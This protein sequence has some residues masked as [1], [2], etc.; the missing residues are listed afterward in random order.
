M[1]QLPR[2]QHEFDVCV[3]GGG[4]AGMIAAMASARHGAKTCLVHDRPVLG[5]NASSEVRMW[6]CGPQKKNLKETGILEEIQLENYY[7]NP[8]LNYSIWDSVLYGKAFFEPNL[9]TFLNTTCNGAEMD[10]DRIASVT[11]WT[12]T[13]QTWQVISAKQFIDCSGDGILGGVTPALWRSGR[14]SREE[15]N[16]SIQPSQADDKTMGNSLLIQIRKTDSPQPFIP[17]TWAYK[18]TSPS[19]IPYR[20]S[21]V[22][23]SNFW[24]IELGGLQDTIGD[25]EAIRDELMRAVYGIWDYIKNHAAE[26]EEAANWALEWIG[27]LP[28]KRENRRFVGDHILTQNDIREQRHFDDIVAYG[29]WPMDDHHPAGLLYPGQPTIFHGAPA[30]YAIPLRCLYSK[31]IPNMLFAGRNISATHIAFAS[32]RVMATC[33]VGGQAVGTA[34]ALWLGEKS[35][36][37]RALSTPANVRAL[38]QRLLRD[39]A[40]LLD[41]RNEEPDDLARAA[42]PSATSGENTAALAID[43]VTRDLRASFGAWSSDSEH[44]WTSTALPASLALELPAA[45]PIREVHL[46]FDSGFERELILTPAHWHRQHSAPRGPQA[47]IVSHYRVKIDGKVV[48]EETGNFLRKRVHRLAAPVIGRVIEIECLATHDAPIARIF[49]V[50]CYA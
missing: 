40:F 4:M 10:G 44:A 35:N 26:K 36:D 28:G 17:P 23:G 21:G 7:R 2:V 29:G 14:E 27:S 32:T 5:G 43:G 39:D 13:S 42:T 48:H 30:P 33:A 11:C 20:M 37:I 22:N 15:F 41:L 3:I 9:T 46:T 47:K 8:S 45:K 12:L 19:D 16:E 18:F 24:W 6:I 38:Q 31:N 1:S 34:A 50:R 49:E 25:A